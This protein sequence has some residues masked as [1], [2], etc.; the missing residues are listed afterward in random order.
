MITSNNGIQLIKQFEGFSS[1]PYL[2]SVGV[3][4]I[5]IGTTF[6]MNGVRVS[7]HD[8]PITEQSAIQILEFHL[9]T[10]EESLAKLVTSHINQNQFDAL[11]SF[12]YNLG[13]NAFEGSTLRRLINANPNDPNI[14][15]QFERWDNAGG[16]QLPG[17][18][19]RRVKEAQLYVS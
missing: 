9:K 12:C 8:H 6:Y 3:A 13:V 10:I 16:K 19:T 18:Y 2:D 4:T 5:G 15:A 11:V 17:L 14:P 7:I 1:N